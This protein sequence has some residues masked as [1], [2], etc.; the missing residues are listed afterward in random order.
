MT[1]IPVVGFDPSLRG[2]GIAE[3][4]LDL[5]TGVLDTPRLTVVQPDKIKSKMVR[6]NSQ[7]L[8]RADQLSQ[9]ALNAARGAKVIFVEIP[10]GS[11]SARAMA[12][13]GMC[14]GIL[15]MIRIMGHPMIEVTATDVKK[16]LSGKSG[17]SKDDMI[18]AAYD[19]YPE[20]NWPTSRE[21][22]RPGKVA[23]KAEHAAD[24]I[25]SIH[26]GVR[27]TDFQSFHR[28]FAKVKT[29]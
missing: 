18:Q 13:Y 20:A 17:A 21:S 5:T 9:A 26:A 7:D 19:I 1:I 28:L 14:I 27:T 4:N 29:P 2:W 23:D 11:Q 6:V 24:A 8:F 3:A 12:S 22:R 15:S 10:V 25:G 16:A